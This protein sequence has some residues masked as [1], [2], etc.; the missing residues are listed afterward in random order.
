M[1]TILK[2]N[3]I[4][5]FPE[6]F[7]GYFRYGVIKRAI[8]K[9]IVEIN[10]YNLRD[11][12]DDAHQTVDDSP[13]GG[14]AGMVLKVEPIY[15]CIKSIKSAKSLRSVKSK[16]R[17]VL[18]SAKGKTYTQKDAKRLAKYDNLI[19]ICGRYEG[20]DERVAEYIADEEISI[21]DY[22][23]TGGELP[24]M[25]LVDSIARLLPGVLGNPDSLKNESFN[26]MLKAKNSEL[27]TDLEFPHYTRPEIFRKWKVPEVL[28]H[29][30]HKEID[31]WRE[32]NSKP[33][34]H[35]LSPRA[36]N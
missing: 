3:I 6:M 32:K 26:K 30:N 29:G 20:V 8:E 21:G 5:I 14:G 25:I 28:L 16:S 11:F 36:L 33:H 18:F 4:T 10:F 22:I 7:G 15:K 23:L 31:A 1:K 12:T 24:A 17:I 19:F 13:Y 9:K 27:T 35:G 34:Q 2:F